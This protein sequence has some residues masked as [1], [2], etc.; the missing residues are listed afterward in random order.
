LGLFYIAP[1]NLL[2]LARTLPYSSLAKVRP[3]SAIMTVDTRQNGHANTN[4][5]T[6][7]NTVGRVAT[8]LPYHKD[9]AER[10]TRG[11]LMLFDKLRKLETLQPDPINGRLFNQLFDLVTISK[12]TTSQEE[13]VRRPRFPLRTRHPSRAR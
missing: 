4:T 11:I 13:K 10:I 3:Y 7:N 9:A 1:S 2:P 8:K 5:T 12:T 6:T